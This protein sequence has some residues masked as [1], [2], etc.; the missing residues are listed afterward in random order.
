VVL[1]PPGGAPA[2]GAGFG[3]SGGGGGGTA[4]QPW[5]SGALQ[6]RRRCATAF[7]AL[8]A[9]A[10]MVAAANLVA[11]PPPLLLGR[12]SPSSPA[13]PQEPPAAL[14]AG[15]LALA[16]APPPRPAQ[17]LARP[18]ARRL[19]EL[20]RQ[21]ALIAERP[22]PAERRVAFVHKS[23]DPITLRGIRA[24]QLAKRQVEA[25]GGWYRF[26]YSLYP[27]PLPDAA[28]G[29]AS[30]RQ[31]LTL[32]ALRAALGDAAVVAVGWDQVAAAVGEGPLGEYRRLLTDK[33]RQGPEKWAWSTNDVVDVAWCARARRRRP[34]RARR[35]GQE[36]FRGRVC[37]RQRV[38]RAAGQ[39]P[40][41]D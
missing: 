17:P 6:R 8:A 7:T 3:G 5:P 26:V 39:G 30:E 40:S 33:M 29:P 35:E 28:A 27:S 24:A 16:A 37:V 13:P 2:K 21:A 22:R 12:R 25:A 32:D 38:M 9:L 41:S 36:S 11:R 31:R 18:L 19:R 15:A 23:A 1:V 14:A 10:L 34:S 4:L 20:R